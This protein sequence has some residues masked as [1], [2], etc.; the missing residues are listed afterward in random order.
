MTITKNRLRDNFSCH[1]NGNV[2]YHLHR[3][4][5][6]ILIKLQ[7]KHWKRKFID[8]MLMRKDEATLRKEEVSYSFLTLMFICTHFSFRGSTVGNS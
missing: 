2:R 4:H 7:N 6:S 1:A 5:I 3:A 8:E